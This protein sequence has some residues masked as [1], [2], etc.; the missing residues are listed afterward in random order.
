MPNSSIIDFYKV[1]NTEVPLKLQLKIGH[2]QNA[3]TTVFLDSVKLAGNDDNG[4]FVRS[5]TIPSL[6]KN[7]D[8]PGK[9]LFITTIVHDIS[10]HT[11]KTSVVLTLEGGEQSYEAKKQ[12]TV[13]PG[14]IAVYTVDIEFFL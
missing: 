4:S 2:R 12:M 8:L 9:R 3:V 1:N 14:A 6:G 7:K 5:F 10:D 13:S 11:N